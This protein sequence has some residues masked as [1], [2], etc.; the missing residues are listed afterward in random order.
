MATDLDR[1]GDRGA[2]LDF[3]HAHV[4]ELCGALEA[5]VG[6]A[7]EFTSAELDFTQFSCTLQQYD[8]EYYTLS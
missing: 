4:Q 1:T 2:V 7:L 5:I 8:E 3:G 6:G